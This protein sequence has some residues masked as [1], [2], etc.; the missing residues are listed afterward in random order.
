VRSKV[1]QIKDRRV[2]DDQPV[3]IIA[4]AGVNHNG[5]IEVAKKMIE[6]AKKSGA[7]AIKFQT[8]KA[9]DL[10]TRDAP[11]AK[12][13][14]LNTSKG[15]QYD[16][17]KSLELSENDFNKLNIYC[18]RKK[19][20]FMS[21]PFDP[22]SAEFINKLGVRLFKVS[23]GEITNLPLLKKIA[24]Y[25]K[26]IILSTGMATIKEI[27]EGLKTIYNAG[28]NKVILLHCVSN[29]PARYE[30]ANLKAMNTLKGR[31]KIPIGLSD[32]TLGAEVAVAAVAM[33]ACVIE[34]HFTLD[35]GMCG[36]DH[37]ASLDA[38]ELTQMVQ[39]IRN[40]EKAMGTG[41]KRPVKSEAEV[42]AV[43]RKSI[44]AASDIPKGARITEELL[45][46][47]RPGTG[48]LPK[49]IFSIIGKKAK[50]DISRDHLL[51]WDQIS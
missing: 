28:N 25:G 51:K 33:G 49:Y 41:I 4:E 20:M 35:K 8:F 47:K 31:Y 16:M 21:T 36:P 5:N 12:Y 37:K 10:V 18:K 34:K 27:D 24:K 1:I 32:H 40:C 29:Y 14:R 13:Q 30:D 15:N 7:D 42:K 50:K 11:K 38:K 19:I 17:L 23:S 22:K 44:I 26:P 2:G 43:A 3:F 46:I 6:V 48:I 45:A 39:S 9:D